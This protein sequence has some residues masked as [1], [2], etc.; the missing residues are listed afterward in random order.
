MS[1]FKNP[2]VLDSSQYNRDL[3]ILKHYVDQVSFFLSKKFNVSIEKANDFVKK[4]LKKNGKFEFKDKNI[5]YFERQEN[6]DKIKKNGGLYEYIKQSL[7]NKELIAPTFTTYINSDKLESVL[8]KFTE[9]NISKR[10]KA[11]K[12]MFTYKA[13]KNY[14]MS[15]F[16]S[17]EQNALKIYNNSLSG[18]F[19]SKFT[20]LY[21]KS[22]HS[23]LT[24]TTRSTS[25]YGNA[26]NEKFLSGN[27]HYFNYDV[28]INNIISITSNSDY[29]KINN[30]V[31]KY[32][33]HIP[34]VDDVMDCILYS[35]K[36]YWDEE[37][38]INKLKDLV[39]KLS[40]LEKC[41]F[42][43][44]GDLYH[45]KKHNENLVKNFIL[46]LSKKCNFEVN[47]PMSIIKNTRED[48][49]NLAHQ[50]CA[51]ITKGIGKDHSK[52]KNIN[53]LNTLAST[54]LN[55]KN[56]ITKY[57]DLIDGL[58][59]TK[60]LPA[61]VA[62]FPSSIRR[63]AIVSD[64]DSTIFTVQDWVKWVTDDYSFNEATLS[65]G[66]SV[67]F[68]V[69]SVLEHMLAIMSANFGIS[70]KNLFKIAMK[71]EYTF[72][73]FIPTNNSKHYFA[74]KS[75]QEGNVFE[76][77]DIEIKGVHLKNSNVPIYISEQVKIMIKDILDDVEKDVIVN[78]IT[79]LNRVANIE[80]EI[81]NNIKTGKVDFYRTGRVNDLSSYAKEAEQSPYFRHIF[82]NS[83]FGDK[84]GKVGEPPYVT[85]KIN[86]N[87]KS[88]KVFKNWIESINDENIKTNL[89]NYFTK[90]DKEIKTFYIP[91]EVISNK[92]VPEEILPIIDYRKVVK[93]TCNAFYII[94]E[95]IGVF[96]AGSHD[97]IVSDL[98]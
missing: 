67:V 57:S 13:S 72:P 70:K 82:W 93:D 17:H 42:V 38:Y 28:I 36:L 85:Y 7:S 96:I 62:H 73:V 47:D 81:I 89:L 24:S 58:W 48:H 26:N 74:S 83:I 39:S 95:T 22:G 60:N 29:F 1:D 21:N 23:T 34:S 75:C 50:I 86:L 25:A 41:A 91:S 33:L 49:L 68:V 56:I 15:E 65:V 52:I 31:N 44:T 2:F 9:Q 12:E 35:S 84:Y 14:V 69:N 45:L 94:L 61:S 37:Y 78:P 27:R 87:I 5:E 53:D 19:G 97:K 59:I 20:P 3:N 32:N 40:D 6:G 4:N 66:A 76:E 63:A 54:C 16:K 92:G 88:K 77:N 55:I 90:Y 98:Y 64:T 71:N 30:L 18:A 11:K 79:Y 51:N 43:Y 80:R 46:E 10:S 8:S